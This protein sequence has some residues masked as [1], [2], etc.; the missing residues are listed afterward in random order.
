MEIFKNRA[1]SRHQNS[2][3]VVVQGLTFSALNVMHNNSVL[4][5]DLVSHFT[6]FDFIAS[7]P[8]KQRMLLIMPLFAAKDL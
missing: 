7:L 8:E 4:C 3:G 5:I 1:I 6:K 2:T